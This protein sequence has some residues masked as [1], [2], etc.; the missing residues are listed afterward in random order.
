MTQRATETHEPIVLDDTTLPAPPPC[1][2]GEV[3]LFSIRGRMWMACEDRT[4]FG[5][6][7]IF[8]GPG[9]ARRVRHYPGN[10]RELAAEG[11]YELS[12]SS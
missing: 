12:L 3:R 9:I 7:L 8:F 11:L 5:P 6:A 2:H 4:E 10:W 1:A